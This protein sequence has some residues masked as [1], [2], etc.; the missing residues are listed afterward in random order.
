MR[1]LRTADQQSLFIKMSSMWS[2]VEMMQI[3]STDVASV[4]LRYKVEAREIFSTGHS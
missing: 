1:K 2:N 4:T 3:R